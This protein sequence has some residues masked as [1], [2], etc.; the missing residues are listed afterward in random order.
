LL[1][2]PRQIK[3]NLA[4][5]NSAATDPRPLI[6][7]T[8]GNLEG[9][10]PEVVSRALK[11]LGDTREVSARLLVL[12]SR[13]VLGRAF[14]LLG[15]EGLDPAALAD[16]DPAGEP[17]P[18]DGPLLLDPSH[19]HADFTPGEM[20]PEVARHPRAYLEE[21]ARLALQGRVAALV[22]GPIDKRIFTLFGPRVHG[23]TE[24]FA[25]RAGNPQVLM[26]MS[27]PRL[28]VGLLTT[29][30]PLA[31]VREALSEVRIVSGLELLARFLKQRDPE[32]TPRLA[33]AGL[34]PHLGDDGLAGRED[35]TLVAPAVRAAHSRGLDVTG[36]VPADSVF[37][38]ARLGRFDGVLALYHDQGMIPVKLLDFDR[39][40][41][42]TVGLPFW[43][44]SPDHGVARDIAWR[45]EARAESMLEAIRLAAR[46][47]GPWP[48]PG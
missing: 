37:L 31:G 9:V 23:Q 13:A 24:F 4:M 36:P 22:T 30:I 35:H 38:Q 45:G 25:L 2:L 10:G 47:S 21:A 7:I 15:D 48:R 3:E 11:T 41:N 20:T 28:T 1:D 26:V 6:A 32:R 44:T 12:G 42:V 14:E 46:L 18:G 40:V 34:N 8:L 19:A 5:S 39:T 27:G 33:V 17:P 43:R 16:F 29:H